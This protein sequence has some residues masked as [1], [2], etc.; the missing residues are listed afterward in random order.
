LNI[1]GVDPSLECGMA[2]VRTDG[3]ELIAST[4][5]HPGSAITGDDRLA[6]ITS[7]AQNWVH[8][9][10]RDNWLALDA[11]AIEVP[12]VGRQRVSPLQWRLVGRLEEMWRDWPVLFVS[13]SQAKLAV[14]LKAR[15]ARKPVAEVEA[16]VNLS[17]LSPTKYV[18]EAVAD[19]IAVAIAAHGILE[20]KESA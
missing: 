11:I 16:L 15:E 17:P 19:A 4:C 8:R 12:S 18:R 1:L 2:F 3:P 7:T 6:W 5:I 10:R 20:A 14:G 9:L 13:P